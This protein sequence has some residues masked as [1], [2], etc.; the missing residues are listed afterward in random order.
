[1]GGGRGQDVLPCSVSGRQ[2]E[3]FMFE[4]RNDRANSC[5]N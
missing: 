2:V 1:M 3:A 4:R 5:L